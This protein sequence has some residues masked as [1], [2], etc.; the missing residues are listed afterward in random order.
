MRPPVQHP[1]KS[2]GVRRRF[3][4]DVAFRY[5][6]QAMGM[7]K[8]LLILPL[9]ARAFGE[10]SYGIW[11]QIALSVALLQSVATL[12]LG[13]ALVRYLTE[14]REGIERRRAVWMANGTVLGIGALVVACVLCFRTAFAFMLFGTR[15]LAEFIP[16]FAML[17]Y[18]QTLLSTGI[19]YF[20]ASDQ[21]RAGTLLQACTSLGS[22]A[23]VALVV[24]GFRASLSQA[25]FAWAASTALG[26]LVAQFAI[27]SQQGA[28]L[29]ISV[30]TLRRFLRYS[31]PLVPAAATVWIIEYSDRFFVVHLLG[32]SQA[33]IYAGAYRLAQVMR[34]LMTPM[35]FVLL[36]TVLRLRRDGTEALGQQLMREV[37]AAYLFVGGGVAVFLIACGPRLLLLLGIAGAQVSQGFLALLV[38]GEMALA[39]RL[40]HTQLLYLSERTLTVLLIVGGTAAMNVIANLFLVPA[41]GI[42]GAALS[43]FASYVAQWLVMLHVIEQRASISVPRRVLLRVV[44]GAGVAYAVLRL[45]NSSSLPLLLGGTAAA[46]LVYL[47]VLWSSGS[48]RK[49]VRHV[50]REHRI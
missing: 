2:A 23:I 31:L 22:I 48:I 39:F 20:R 3:L 49:M 50:F 35:L 11:S 6:A 34:L 45:T 17:L 24:V 28:P 9:I 47:S 1:I 29:R 25:V 4:G 13:S 32:L 5:A 36:P 18:A 42:L 38:L 44:L 41:L 27:V 26:A 10:A 46:V 43:T 33:G 8:G 14:T 16:P 7:L 15:A 19:A 37:L 30:R 21:L 40:L 12:R